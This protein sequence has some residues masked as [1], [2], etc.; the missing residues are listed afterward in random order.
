MNKSF[1][2]VK[3]ALKT[4]TSAVSSITNVIKDKSSVLLMKIASS[5]P[6]FVRSQQTAGKVIWGGGVGDGDYKKSKAFMVSYKLLKTLEKKGCD[7]KLIAPLCNFRDRLESNVSN[8][9]NA[10]KSDKVTAETLNCLVAVWMWLV[11]LVA[12]VGLR[13]NQNKQLVW[14]A[15]RGSAKFAWEISDTKST[16]ELEKFTRKRIEEF[17][18]EIL[19]KNMFEKLIGVSKANESIMFTL[20]LSTVIGITAIIAVITLYRFV[21]FAYYTFRQARLEFSEFIELQ[22]EYLS[23]ESGNADNKQIA[24]NLASIANK[25]SNIAKTIGEDY[26]SLEKKVDQKSGA[27][28]KSAKKIQDEEQKIERETSSAV[29]DTSVSSGNDLLF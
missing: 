18:K 20:A 23:A 15:N 10:A 29:S 12:T 14:S 5:D 27:F 21:Q 3:K 26:E 28:E 11:G 8:T 17:D 6:D 7:R 2:P 25:V 22:G 9:K 24:G 1:K 13:P 19:K 16:A 4:A